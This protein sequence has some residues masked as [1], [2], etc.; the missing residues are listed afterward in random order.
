VTFV[1]LLRPRARRDLRQIWLDSV[2]NWGVAQANEYLRELSSKMSLLC[3]QPYLGRSI[4]E[5]R[6]GFHQCTAGSHMIFYQVGPGRIE[7]ARILHQ[8]MYPIRHL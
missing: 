7:V 8:R 6:A 4:P 1:L 2:E 5:V 3:E